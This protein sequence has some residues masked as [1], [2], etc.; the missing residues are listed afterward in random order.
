MKPRKS[1]SPSSEAEP[2][3]HSHFAVRS[4]SKA[5]ILDSGYGRH[6][7]VMMRARI[8]DILRRAIEDGVRLGWETAHETLERPTDE[9]VRECQVQAVIDELHGYFDFDDLT[10]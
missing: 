7:F 10:E 9:Q 8:L 2:R 5:A 1:Y 6:H 3:H 4:N